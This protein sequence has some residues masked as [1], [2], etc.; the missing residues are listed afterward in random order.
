MG[1]VIADIFATVVTIPVLG[2][3]VIYFIT[4]ILT[5]NQKRAVLLSSDITTFLFILSV[6]F[7]IHEIW[8]VYPGWLIVTVLAIIA[9]FFAFLRWN[10]K[11]DLALPKIVKAMWRFSF[12]MF[13]AAYF[14]LFFY[15]LVTRLLRV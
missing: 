3:F 4:L 6:Y 13:G 5:G 1:N 9:C 15:G 2:W 11:N 12:F 14:V 10:L 7:I 8:Q